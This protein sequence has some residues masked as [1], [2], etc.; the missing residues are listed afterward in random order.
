MNPPLGLSGQ[1]AGVGEGEE[2]AE[3]GQT[4][5]HAKRPAHLELR[6]LPAGPSKLPGHCPHRQ[7]LPGLREGQEVGDGVDGG[8]VLARL[9]QK[10]ALEPG[11]EGTLRNVPHSGTGSG[12]HGTKPGAP[13]GV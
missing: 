10:L 2:A 8:C 12:A 4:L 9:R 5:K 1:W 13:P 11:R 6:P 7:R 3:Q